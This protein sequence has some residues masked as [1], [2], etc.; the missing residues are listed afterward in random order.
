MLSSVL[1]SWQGDGRLWND[2]EQLQTS[3]NEGSG[4]GTTTMK[5]R[6]LGQ[7]QKWKADSSRRQNE[8]HQACWCHYIN[9]NLFFARAVALLE[10]LRK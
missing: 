6:T 9:G 10:V 8:A 3:G 5:A 7:M 4:Q 2:P 1:Q